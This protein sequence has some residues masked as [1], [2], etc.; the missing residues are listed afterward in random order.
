[1]INKL[2]A[3]TS[4][5]AHF[6]ISDGFDLLPKI[7][8]AYFHQVDGFVRTILSFTTPRRTTREAAEANRPTRI[9]AEPALVPVRIRR[10]LPPQGSVEPNWSRFSKVKKTF[11]T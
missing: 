7:E 6:Q 1:M 10:L 11:R 5:V 3:L 8:G 4:Q 2:T 9:G